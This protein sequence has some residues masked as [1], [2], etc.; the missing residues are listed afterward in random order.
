MSL[1]HHLLVQSIQNSTKNSLKIFDS[2]KN[3]YSTRTSIRITSTRITKA[4]FIF[5]LSCAQSTIIFLK[6]FINLLAPTKS[7]IKSQ[8][9]INTTP[10]SFTNTFSI[11]A[12]S[13]ARTSSI[14]SIWI[15][16]FAI[17]SWIR[18]IQ[19]TGIS[20]H[21]NRTCLCTLHCL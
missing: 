17:I 7:Y 3:S 10:A 9:T 11:C 13:M 16:S 5:N 21:R 2:S 18:T 4:I 15:G 20:A 8:T 1:L 12:C 14:T 19:D 6:K